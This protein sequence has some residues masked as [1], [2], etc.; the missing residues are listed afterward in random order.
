MG[1]ISWKSNNITAIN[2]ISGLYT[3]T[4]I[5][6]N[7]CFN[8]TTIN[9]GQPDSLIVDTLSTTNPYCA[10]VNDGSIN[11]D[12]SGGTFPLITSWTNQANTF[13]STDQNIDSLFLGTYIVTVT[14]NNGCIA[15]D[16]ITLSPIVEIIVNAGLDTLVCLGDSLIITGS[17]TGTN[18][19]TLEWLAIIHLL[20]LTLLFLP[21]PFLQTFLICTRFS[22]C[23]KFYLHC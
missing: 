17:S 23:H 3:I 18:T 15:I 8:D 9:V 14:D 13:V 12:I 20:Q 11:L 10:S 5:D 22:K 6:Q 4:V 16:S 19:P 1:R 7:G 2:I 21:D